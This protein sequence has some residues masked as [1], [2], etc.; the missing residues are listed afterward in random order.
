MSDI[1]T[2]LQQGGWTMY[3]LGFCSLAALTLILERGVALR[4]GRVLPPKLLRRVHASRAAE[5]IGGVATLCIRNSSPLARLIEEVSSMK[6]LNHSQAV[7]RMHAIGH[8]QVARLD[9][10]LTLLEI[11][12]AISPLLGLL[13]TVLGMVEVFEAVTAEGLGDP[14]ILSD[15]IAKALSTTI[16]GLCVAIPTLAFHSIYNKRVEAFATEMQDAATAFLVMLHAPDQEERR[17]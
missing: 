17:K 13:G 4:R 6:N 2:F 7:E 12:A 3:A 8:S 15:G 1:L 9:R 16:A 5:D 10:G 11:I 14:Q